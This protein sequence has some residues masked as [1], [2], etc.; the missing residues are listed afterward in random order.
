MSWTP[1]DDYI[2]PAHVCG[3]CKH[4]R[5]VA[6][7][8]DEPYEKVGICGAM[9][10]KGIEKYPQMWDELVTTADFDDVDECWEE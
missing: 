4:F 8:E 6:I 9:M 7:A 3:T 5:S 2:E 10:S 1:Y